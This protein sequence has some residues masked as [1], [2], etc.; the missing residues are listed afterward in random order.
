MGFKLFNRENDF[1]SAEP[2]EE[3]IE[4]NVMDSESRK[5]TGSI[6]ITV[7]KL[8]EFPDTERVL[9]AV[10]E[11][12]IV[13]LKIKHLKDKD[14]GELKRA[15]DKLKKTVTANNGDIAGVEQDWLILTPEFAKVMREV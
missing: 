2:R 1:D 5:R 10:R 7:E 14:I 11:G 12:N 3:F 9:R 13:F 15:V 8:T 6:G 4:V